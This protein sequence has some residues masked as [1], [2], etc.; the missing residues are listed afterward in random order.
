LSDAAI[1]IEIAD[2]G[3]AAAVPR[4]R[5][6]HEGEGVGSQSLNH[7][8]A[9]SDI[10]GNLP[11]LEAVIDDIA[12][13]GIVAI[14]NLGDSLSGPLWP[15]ETGA[16]LMALDW[17]TIAGNHDRQLVDRPISQMG[18]NDA[19]AAARLTTDVRAWIGRL[20][21][22]TTFAETVFL[23][24]GTPTQ[25]DAYWLHRGTRGDMREARPEEIAADAVD[26]PLA[27]CGHTHLS[28]VVRLDDGRLIAN[29]GSVGFPAKQDKSSFHHR[30]DGKNPNA[31]YLTA[32]RRDEG[33]AVELQ[34]VAYDVEAA[35]RQAERN[36]RSKWALALRTGHMPKKRG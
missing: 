12:A 17:P 26:A 8:A 7:F 35:A 23:C 34:T 14:V 4:L 9:V 13:R 33:W 36:G 27:L 22:T 11:A 15:A 25:D 30:A 28:R 20:P 21:A 24:H 32:R 16:R 5:S 2:R 3:P 6:L 31:Q 10:H 18:R 29:P 1:P 19:Y